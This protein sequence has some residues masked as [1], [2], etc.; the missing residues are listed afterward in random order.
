MRVDLGGYGN[1]VTTERLADVGE[2]AT[3]R[4]DMGD[5]QG[6]GGQCGQRELRRETHEDS[7]YETTHAIL[8]R[9]V[10]FW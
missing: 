5:A 2:R 10:V 6:F 8:L 4:I 3:E 7:G 1:Q 9:V